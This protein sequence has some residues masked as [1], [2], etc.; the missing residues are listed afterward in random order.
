MSFVVFGYRKLE[1]ESLRRTR[2]LYGLWLTRGPVVCVFPLII[3]PFF[4]SRRCD[5]DAGWRHP[6]D[7]P[8]RR[9]ANYRQTKLAHVH[10]HLPTMLAS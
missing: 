7:P 9:I 3:S 2:H 5:D 4:F 6:A 1:V 10:G 8:Q